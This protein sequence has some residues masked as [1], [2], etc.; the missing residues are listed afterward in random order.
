MKASFGDDASAVKKPALNHF[1]YRRDSISTGE[2]VEASS[3]PDG[4]AEDI[5]RSLDYALFSSVPFSRRDAR[6][7]IS[8]ERSTKVGAAL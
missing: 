7:G 4:D 8:P 1:L 5:E 6:F 3:A 2:K